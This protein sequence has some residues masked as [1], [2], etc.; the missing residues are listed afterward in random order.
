MRPS[1]IASHDPASVPVSGS[2]V[3]TG[4]VGAAVVA[5]RLSVAIS[6]VRRSL[7]P[8]GVY[9]RSSFVGVDRDTVWLEI[10]RVDV[11]LER[12]LEAASSALRQQESTVGE[13]AEEVLH[14]LQRA[15]AL[16]DG[17]AFAD[18]PYDD[19]WTATRERVRSAFSELCHATAASARTAG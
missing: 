4:V 1:A 3:M 5:N 17:V 13:P 19:W 11:D 10:S 2:V 8:D 12:F 18:D 6:T 15:A 14:R 9:P 16:H 7:D